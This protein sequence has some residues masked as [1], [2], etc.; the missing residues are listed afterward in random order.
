MKHLHD[1][2]LLM[3][4]LDGIDDLDPAS[5]DLKQAKQFQALSQ[6]KAD[7]KLLNDVPECQL[8]SERLRRRILDEGMQPQRQSRGWFWSASAGAISYACMAAA[9]VM[10]WNWYQP[11]PS[12]PPQNLAL[13][14]PVTPTLENLE[15]KA[16]VEKP[17]SAPQPAAAAVSASKPAPSTSS[18]AKQD[19]RRQNRPLKIRTDRPVLTMASASLEG[20]GYLT[21]QASPVTPPP[22]PSQI[23]ADAMPPMDSAVSTS[24]SG[25]AAPAAK[26]SGGSR[27]ASV[28]VI[29]STPEPTMESAG[30][31]VFGG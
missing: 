17:D 11:A 9:A 13:V 6:L 4:A 12:A 18:A 7:L 26:P 2:E 21:K 29:S 31:V 30:H 28:V 22:G 19:K 5:L 24:V 20:V 8:S 25:Q 1:D 23:S 14:A 16:P 10:I 27:S 3:S 15:T